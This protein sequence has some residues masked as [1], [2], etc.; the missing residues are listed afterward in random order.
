MSFRDVFWACDPIG[1]GL[2][3]VGSLLTLLALDWA[4]GTYAWADTHVVAPLTI[5]LVLL[6]AFSLYGRYHS[7]DQ[8]KNRRR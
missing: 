1:S 8:L 7:K 3:I 4:A 5:G 6:V 2:F